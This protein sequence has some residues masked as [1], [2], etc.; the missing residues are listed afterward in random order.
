MCISTLC[1]CRIALM[2]CLHCSWAGLTKACSIS[3]SEL[4]HEHMVWFKI[5]SVACKNARGRILQNATG[6]LHERYIIQ[7]PAV[8]TQ[9]SFFFAWQRS[10]L[11]CNTCTRCIHARTRTH[12]HVLVCIDAL[13]WHPAER[14]LY[15][16]RTTLH[17][18]LSVYVSTY[19]YPLQFCRICRT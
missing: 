11:L 17:V 14:W 1:H 9:Y 18:C 16:L 7:L 15:A 5:A 8:W 3:A 2:S 4:R 6:C 12:G 19:A 10:A 13:G